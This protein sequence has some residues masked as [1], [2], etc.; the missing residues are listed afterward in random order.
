VRKGE[1]V[2]KFSLLFMVVAMAVK[3]WF[4]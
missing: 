3:L 2:I 4:F 1:K